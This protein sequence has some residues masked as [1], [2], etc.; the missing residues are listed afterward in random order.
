VSEIKKLLEELHAD[1]ARALKTKLDGEAT[2]ADL[3]VIRQF[4]KDNNISGL[5]APGSPLK[6]LVDG[7]PFD[8]PADRDDAIYN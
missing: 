4:L 2:A 3:N 6:A 1:L 5:P 7:M 8:T